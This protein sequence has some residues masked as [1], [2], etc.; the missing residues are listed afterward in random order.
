MKKNL[1]HT[2]LAMIAIA[3]I[4]A[5]SVK[6]GMDFSSASQERIRNITTGGNQD[7][8]TITEME[9]DTG[10]AVAILSDEETPSNEEDTEDIEDETE[11]E[12]KT[13]ELNADEQKAEDLGKTSYFKVGYVNITSGT[14]EVRGLPS[15]E[16]EIID[17]VEKLTEVQIM[18]C[19]E[20]WYKIGYGDGSTGYVRTDFITE[21][22]SEAKDSAKNYTN[23]KTAHIDSSSVTV[24]SSASSDA[25]AVTTLSDNDSIVVLGMEDGFVKIA[26][27]S[28]YSEGYIVAG[29][30]SGQDGWIEKS[31]VAEVQQQAKE[32][33]EAAKVAEAAKAAQAAAAAK[34]TSTPAKSSSSSSSSVSSSTSSS[35]SS[36]SNASGQALV[37]TAK[38][39][40]GT[41]YVWGGSSPSG[42]DCSG[43]VQY[44]CAQNGISVPRT[45][46]DQAKVGVAVS[47]S[48]LQPGD[49]LFFAKNGVVH[50]VG[51][52][53][54][55]GQMIHSPQTGDVV[56]ISSINTTYRINGYYC[57]RRVT[58][59]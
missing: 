7:V 59:N 2:V 30:V 54:G 22:L 47:K 42:F 40:L 25:T 56:K 27:G 38:K 35:S 50:H 16:A 4:S 46:R 14:L 41:K 24:R 53:I 11:E 21:D 32:A 17:N 34:A 12:S 52:Y 43:F 29:A 48:D 55:N 18:E 49:L 31:E 20:G 44:V 13:E 39:Y 1:K 57:A 5:L 28:D 58:S 37:A 26:Y 19:T 51:I 15:S 6:Q 9:S 8:I 45:S 10:L 23:Y 36:S 33:A 3:M